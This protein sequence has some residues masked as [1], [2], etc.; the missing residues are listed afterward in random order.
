M[1]GWTNSRSIDRETGRV[2]AMLSAASAEVVVHG[3]AASSDAERSVSFFK[4]PEPGPV[5][6]EFPDG[7]APALRQHFESLG[8]RDLAATVDRLEHLSRRLRTTTGPD[9]E[10]SE[11]LYQMH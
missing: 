8:L 1:R 5:L 4:E 11:M 3:R 6:R 2:F 10:V 9:R 7:V